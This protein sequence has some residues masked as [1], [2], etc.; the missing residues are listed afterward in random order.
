M[1]T[2]CGASLALHDAGKWC[3]MYSGKYSTCNTSKEYFTGII[4]E[5][6]CK[7]TCTYML[8]I[9]HVLEK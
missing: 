4:I 6:F 8:Y 1:A 5:N 7:D 3:Y 9:I 2:V